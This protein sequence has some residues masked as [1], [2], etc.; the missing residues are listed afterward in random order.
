MVA[1]VGLRGATT[2]EDNSRNS[3]L[4]ATKDL[5][6]RIIDENDLDISQVVA[7]WFT[8]TSDLNAEYPALAARQLG[9]MNAALLCAHEMA[10]PNGLPQC[11]RV[12]ILVNTDKNPGDL[13]FVYLKG[14]QGL[15]TEGIEP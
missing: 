11:I 8:T 1:C 2:A 9:W 13:R 7:A 10:V 12:L 3:I 5:L 15:R 4:T 14:A 6:K